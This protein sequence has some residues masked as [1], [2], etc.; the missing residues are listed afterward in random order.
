MCRYFDSLIWLAAIAAWTENAFNLCSAFSSDFY[1]VSSLSLFRIQF[2]RSFLGHRWSV[3]RTLWVVS[4]QTAGC[5]VLFI[6]S[7]CTML[8][9][10]QK[11]NRQ[12]ERK[13]VHRLRNRRPKYWFI[14]DNGCARCK[15]KMKI[16]KKCVNRCDF[17][18]NIKSASAVGGRAVGRSSTRRPV[19]LSI[20]RDNLP[21][22][23]A[24]SI[25]CTFAL[26]INWH[27][28]REWL[29]NSPKYQFGYCGSVKCLEERSNRFPMQHGIAGRIYVMSALRPRSTIN[30]VDGTIHIYTFWC[31]RFVEAIQLSRWICNL[32]G[33]EWQTTI[34]W[35]D[36]LFIFYSREI[37]FAHTMQQH[38]HYLWMPCVCGALK[39]GLFVSV[40]IE[41]IECT[42]QFSIRTVPLSLPLSV[43]HLCNF[44][45][46]FFVSWRK[47]SSEPCVHMPT[48]I[49]HN[50]SRASPIPMFVCV[51]VRARAEGNNGTQ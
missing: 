39:E 19:E 24:L 4:M 38:I 44:K 29:P 10:T 1:F 36:L 47:S 30:V 46:L 42:S 22:V 51:C 33:Q 11:P 37:R 48:F 3:I 2:H 26:S 45:W 21:Y 23:T 6:V 9:V 7:I 27:K 12:K 8:P 20:K 35:T 34:Q 17:Y 25:P 43:F 14:I 15:P 28:S 13:Y 49:T 32:H 16:E 18:E 31:E 41:F 40:A 50:A 5:I